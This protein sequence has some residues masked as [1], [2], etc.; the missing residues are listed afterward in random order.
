MILKKDAK[1]I[2]LTIFKKFIHNFLQPNYIALMIGY[3]L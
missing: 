1:I 3:T 2:T